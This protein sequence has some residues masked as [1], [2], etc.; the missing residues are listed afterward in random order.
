MIKEGE[1]E[2][3]AARGEGGKAA[4]RPDIVKRRTASDVLLGLVGMKR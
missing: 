1:E 4:G 2:D 3:A